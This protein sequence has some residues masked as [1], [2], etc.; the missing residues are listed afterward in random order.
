MSLTSGTN[1]VDF[2]VMEFIEGETLEQR[3]LKGKN[4]T[5][6]PGQSAPMKRVQ[7]SYP[8]QRHALLPGRDIGV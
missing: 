1:G 4:R 7:L 8:Q 3:L 6:G 5:V 2:L